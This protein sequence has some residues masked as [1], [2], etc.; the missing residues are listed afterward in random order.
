MP[1]WTARPCVNTDHLHA[2]SVRR[3]YFSSF[4]FSLENAFI[5]A[6]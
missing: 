3:I 2:V 6:R 4:A 1:I 5:I